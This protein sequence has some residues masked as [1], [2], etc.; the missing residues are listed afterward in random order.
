MVLGVPISK[1][2]SNYFADS[3][4]SCQSSS[5]LS[6]MSS[7][8]EDDSSELELSESLPRRRSQSRDRSLSRERNSSGCHVS[9]Q[10]SVSL[11]DISTISNFNS[12]YY[13]LDFSPTD[14]P[15][16]RQLPNLNS[17]RKHQNNK[18]SLVNECRKIEAS[19]RA[20]SA[21]CLFEKELQI[22][23]SDHDFVSHGNIQKCQHGS[24]EN[25]KNCKNNC[26][27]STTSPRSRPLNR[28]SSFKLSPAKGVDSKD[29]ALNRILSIDEISCK[30]SLGDRSPI[31]IYLDD[32]DEVFFVFDDTS[33]PFDNSADP[34]ADSRSSVSE[35][36]KGKNDLMNEMFDQ[37]DVQFKPE[38]PLIGKQKEKESKENGKS[39]FGLLKS[40]VLQIF[41]RDDDNGAKTASLNKSVPTKIPPRTNN[42]VK[43]MVMTPE[44]SHDLIN[45][46]T[47]LN[48]A[49]REFPMSSCLDVEKCA[50]SPKS[51]KIC[52]K[53]DIGGSNLENK[54]VSPR[55]L[56]KFSFGQ[57]SVDNY[58][59][60]SK[61]IKRLERGD[62]FEK[63]AK[64]SKLDKRQD[65]KFPPNQLQRVNS[66]NDLLKSAIRNSTMKQN[67]PTVEM[68]RSNPFIVRSFSSDYVEDPSTA[69][70]FENMNESDNE[71]IIIESPKEVLSIEQTLYDCFM[72]LDVDKTEGHTSKSKQSSTTNSDKRGSVG[73]EISL[74]S[75]EEMDDQWEYGDTIYSD[76]KI[77]VKLEKRGENKI[78][79]GGTNYIS[80][81]AESGSV[82]NGSESGYIDC[83]GRFDNKKMIDDSNSIYNGTVNGVGSKL[84]DTKL[85]EEKDSGKRT[86]KLSKRKSLNNVRK[87]E[88]KDMCNA[89]NETTHELDQTR[90]LGKSCDNTGTNCLDDIPDVSCVG[91]AKEGSVSTKLCRYYHVFREGELEKLISSH[92]KDLHIVQCFYDHANWC[93][94]AVKVDTDSVGV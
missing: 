37:V 48:F 75:I 82:A 80:I 1:L 23:G 34:S 65:R 69:Y 41:N 86:S 76:E 83:K 45:M 53:F 6:S 54:I 63:N 12:N 64:S 32:D 9:R 28:L 78:E 66:G 26:T 31:D 11:E 4:T 43:Q 71:D 61:S 30:G 72:R 47:K 73:S 8:S 20:M 90:N 88:S 24:L 93:L 3:T 85:N 10:S 39:V 22:N 67:S 60:T 33:A 55:R 44:L 35:P 13:S 94:V 29:S 89:D 52:V 51:P 91:K 87:G 74:D 92:I 16:R 50:E 25:L 2:F 62:S 58:T 77:K 46:A 68:N 59:K 7:F 49:V 27:V 81:E 70:P 79:T 40:K 17:I 19:L 36:K 57:E 14:S 21:G 56:G 15:K 18:S 84:C 38:K 42:H 5:G